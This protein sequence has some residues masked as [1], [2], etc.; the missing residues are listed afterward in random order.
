MGTVSA[1]A[2]KL[3]LSQSTLSSQLKELESRLGHTLLIRGKRGVTLTEAGKFTLDYAN[4]I[5]STGTELLDARCN[6][7]IN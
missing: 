1:A 6:G 7:R 5:F 2:K 3:R 4:T